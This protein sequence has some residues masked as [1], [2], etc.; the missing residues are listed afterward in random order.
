MEEHE[1]PSKQLTILPRF[2]FEFLRFAGAPVVYIRSAKMGGQ[3]D[4]YQPLDTLV[5]GIAIALAFEAYE[6]ARSHAVFDKTAE[7]LFIFFVAIGF[8]TVA[9]F[10]SRLLG[11]KG[12]AREAC[13]T[14]EYLYGFIYA[15]NAVALTVLMAA[16]EAFPGIRCK[17]SLTSVHMTAV[18]TTLNLVITSAVQTV[19]AAGTVYVLVVFC[20]CLAD[21]YAMKWQRV[22]ALQAIS[23]GVMAV[24]SP[25]LYGFSYAIAE[26]LRELL[27]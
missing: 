27:T 4:L 11:G 5:A 22:L 7:Q 26:R 8:S 24:V 25:P 13:V 18:P 2:P 21:L 15:G 19:L 17:L 16:T 20:L 3:S 9:H 12:S 14:F 10:M 23:L 1:P 6:A